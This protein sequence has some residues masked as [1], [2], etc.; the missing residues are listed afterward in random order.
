MSNGMKI[1]VAIM[2]LLMSTLCTVWYFGWIK[3]ADEARAQIMSCMSGTDQSYE[4]Y[5]NCLEMFHQ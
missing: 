2:F 5:E 3:P 4:A 1:E